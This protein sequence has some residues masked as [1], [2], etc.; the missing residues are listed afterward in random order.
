MVT[1]ILY[2][3]PAD[4][5]VRPLRDYSQ[6]SKHRKPNN[7]TR[8]CSTTRKESVANLRPLSDN[9]V[10]TPRLGHCKPHEQKEARLISSAPMLKGS[11]L[12]L[13]DWK[14]GLHIEQEGGTILLPKE[15]SLKVLN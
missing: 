1:S 12:R 9:T 10:S 13:K 7:K 15:G 2:A 3:A 11:R 6:R 4:H 8:N 14:G 5:G